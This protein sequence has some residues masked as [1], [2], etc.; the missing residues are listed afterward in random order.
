MPYLFP[1]PRLPPSFSVTLII[2]RI[3]MCTGS[4]SR[5]EFLRHSRSEYLRSSAHPETTLE[6]GEYPQPLTV[7]VPPYTPRDLPH[8]EAEVSSN[9][10][11]LSSNRTRRVIGKPWYA[12]RCAP[13][14]SRAAIRRSPAACRPACRAHEWFTRMK[15]R[16]RKSS[17]SPFDLAV[18]RRQADS[19]LR[20]ASA[21]SRRTSS[22]P[23][24]Q[25]QRPAMQRLGRCSIWGLRAPARCSTVPAGTNA[26][27]KGSRLKLTVVR[28]IWAG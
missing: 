22:W 25:L 20:P 13:A 8:L 9:P 15:R 18:F 26:A 19:E 11:S 3:W 10:E 16:P 7:L 1:L 28:R 4:Y 14:A 21:I 27:S 6:S 12:G 5:P 2:D 17:V 23:E 24:K